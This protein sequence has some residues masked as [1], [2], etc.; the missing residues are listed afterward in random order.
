MLETNQR[1]LTWLCMHP[2]DESATAWKRMA[3]IIAALII[4]AVLLS[5]TIAHIVY[6]LKFVSTDLEG[7]L[8]ALMIIDGMIGFVYSFVTAFNLRY[9]IQTIFEN[10]TSIY[11]ASK[12]LKHSLET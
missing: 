8:V 9:K 10:L 1:V 7:S 6:F 12:D 5:A 3:Y 11:E 2:P 4:F